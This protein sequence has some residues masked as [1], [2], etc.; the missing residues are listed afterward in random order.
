MEEE[1][2][3]QKDTE[4]KQV[5]TS[6]TKW[7]VFIG[8]ALGLLLRVIGVDLGNYEVNLVATFVLPLS[9][10]WGGLFLKEEG[11]SVRVALLAIGGLV[12]IINGVLY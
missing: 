12:L 4:Q 7:V 3:E 11:A 6:D 1:N 5:R 2:T 10:L 8:V 9:L